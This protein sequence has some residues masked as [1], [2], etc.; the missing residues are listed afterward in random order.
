M[1]SGITPLPYQALLKNED[2][3]KY[4]WRTSEDGTTSSRALTNFERMF[5][6]FNRD[7]YG[8]NCPFIGASLTL[9][10]ASSSTFS[11]AELEKRTTAA[12]IQTRWTYPSVAARLLHDEK[13]LYDIEDEAGIQNWAKRTVK[14]VKAEGGWFALREKLSKETAIPSV[15]GDYCLMYII[16]PPSEDGTISNFDVLMHTH[17]VFTDGAGIRSILNQFLERLAAPISNE[18]IIWGKETDR[19]LPPS[20]LL[21]MEDE[22]EL[23]AGETQKVRLKGFAKPDIGLPVYRPDIHAPTPELRGTQLVAHTFPSTF[24]PALLN[25]GRKHGVKLT[26]VLHASLLK[27]IYDSSEAK[28]ADDDLYKSG[29]AMDL[30]NGY[31]YPEYCEKKVY[32]NSAVAI[33]PMDVPCSLFMDEKSG[34]WKAAEYI[35]DEWAGIQKKR[36]IA[37]ATERDAKGFIANWANMK[38]VLIPTF[39]SKL[40]RNRNAP[41]GAPSKPRTCPYFVSDPP[42]SQLLSSTYKIESTGCVGMEIVLESYQLATDQSQ[43]VV[44]ARS[45]SWNDKLTLC[46]VFNAMRNPKEKMQEFLDAWVGVVEGICEGKYN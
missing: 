21:G 18:E 8:Q 40:T 38:C 19:L 3:A 29:S 22:P 31:M 2:E 17:H 27:A 20:L 44:S 10:S 41:K 35:R 7:L 11:S 42:G 23:P 43:A 45:H 14:V 6:I 15:D 37:K 28:P 1:P 24:L 12:F 39:L 13:A 5:V 9:Q 46:L 34:F 16:I 36:G 26:S 32:V 30:R 25:V 4:L 33:Q